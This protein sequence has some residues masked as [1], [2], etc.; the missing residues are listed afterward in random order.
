MHECPSDLP[1]RFKITRIWEE[2]KKDHLD[3][4]VSSTKKK[5]QIL[6]YGTEWP[7]GAATLFVCSEETILAQRNVQAAEEYINRFFQTVKI[8]GKVEF[9]DK[10]PEQ[11]NS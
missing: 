4:S 3:D 6:A 8:R 9:L 10:K 5:E 2:E 7:S 1:R 11:K